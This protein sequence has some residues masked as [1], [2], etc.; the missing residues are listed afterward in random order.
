MRLRVGVNK[1]QDKGALSKEN[2]LQQR[3]ENERSIGDTQRRTQFSALDVYI[4]HESYTC[5][6]P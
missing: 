1:S 4:S 3:L 5:S 6:G 2:I